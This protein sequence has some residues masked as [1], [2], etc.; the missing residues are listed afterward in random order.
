MV[1]ED[2]SVFDPHFGRVLIE[3]KA[4]VELLGSVPMESA[5]SAT[6]V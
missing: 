1:E 3:D 4:A 6:I 2:D 5:I